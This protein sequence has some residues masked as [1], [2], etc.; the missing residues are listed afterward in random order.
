MS[1]SELT[2]IALIPFIVPDFDNESKAVSYVFIGSYVILT[3]SYCV[4]I[5]ALIRTLRRMS[6]FGDFTEQHRDI[7]SQF[8]VFLFAFISK[9]TL[10]FIFIIGSFHD[11][12]DYSYYMM[13]IL[14]HIFVD[15]IPVTY[16]LFSH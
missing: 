7:L 15:I 6:D 5:V 3:V 10:Q 12:S 4:I 14:S 16:M 11:W 2:M 8:L 1:G 13:Q 9:L